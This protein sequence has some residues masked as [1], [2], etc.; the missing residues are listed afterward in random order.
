MNL[1]FARARLEGEEA[2]G[3]SFPYWG[4]SLVGITLLAGMLL[5]GTQSSV[6][7]TRQSPERLPG[8]SSEHQVDDPAGESST[9]LPSWAEP[10][11][12]DPSRT[13][14]SLGNKNATT[15][16]PAPPSPPSRVPVD[17]GIA[18]LAAAGAGYAVRKL[19]Q[20]DDEE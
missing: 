13:G 12:P 6:A 9:E 19:R 2:K 20:E 17:G 3:V 1:F 11:S 10:S 5:L 16:A 8:S 18:L 14:S 7:Q 4:L 15:N